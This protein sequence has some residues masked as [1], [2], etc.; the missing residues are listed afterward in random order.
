M[1]FV[2]VQVVHLYSSTD[3]VTTWK[4]SFISSKRSYLHISSNLF[5]AHHAFAMCMLILLSVDEILLPKYGNLSTYSRGLPLKVEM[6][7]SCLKHMGYVLFAL[8]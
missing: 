4:K 7:P 8:T 5:I 6:A 1:R 2:S 3:T